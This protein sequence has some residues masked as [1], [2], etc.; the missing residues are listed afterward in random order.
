MANNLI[1]EQS[2]NAFPEFYYTIGI[3]PT[4][5]KI[6]LTYEEQLEEIMKFLRDELIPKFN[7]NAGALGELQDKYVELVQYVN[8]YFSE[9][10]LQHEVDNKL[11]EMVQDG[12]LEEIINQE[13]FTQINEDIADLKEFK[14]SAT[15]DIGNIETDINNIETDITNLET[16]VNNQKMKEIRKKYYSNYHLFDFPTVISDFLK[17]V[18]VYESYDKKNYKYYFNKENLKVT[19][20]NTYYVDSV[21][22]N[23]NNDGLSLANAWKTIHWAYRHTTDNS[24]ILV[25]KGIYYR[26]SMPNSSQNKL[27]RNINI[28]CEE[29]TLIGM[30]DNL[31]YTQNAQYS[32][33][34]EASRNSVNHALD[35][36][37]YEKGVIAQLEEVSTL[38]ECADTLNSFYKDSSKVYINIGEAV[39]SSKVIVSLNINF[40]SFDVDCSNPDSDLTLYLENAT[41]INGTV[42]VLSIK[43]SATHQATFYGINCKFLYKKQTDENYNGIDFLGS[44]SILF[45]CE[46]SFNGKDGF[47]YHANAGKVCNGIELDCIGS[48]NGLKTSINTCNGSTIHDGSQIIRINGKYFNNKGGNVAD[49]QT[50][51]ISYNFN[52]TS[53]DSLSSNASDSLKA[54]FSNQQAGGTMYLYN[55]YSKGSNSK[56]NIY[57]NEDATTYISNCEY[58]TSVG[59]I[60]EI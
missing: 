60:I 25:K 14:T 42:P 3:L 38:S 4:S 17:K 43:S 2:L 34:Y 6:S 49:V 27:Q 10:N 36:R 58:D 7:N 13:I 56:C 31:S 29:G 50:G 59:N 57:C 44:N 22:G 15:T 28:I 47:N 45:N 8:D 53:F 21:N 46:S 9:L 5:Y 20:G 40:S 23:D 30:F 19:G 48:Y 16:N 54:D 24:T 41:I 11:E 1:N 12:T 37:N 51:S 18:P 26:D 39:D 55:C 32:N 52:C 33:V 35:I